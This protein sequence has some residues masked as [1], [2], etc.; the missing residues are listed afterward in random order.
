M[1]VEYV[2]NVD[3]FFHAKN[4]K[5]ADEIIADILS[6][7]RESPKIDEAHAN[8]TPKGGDR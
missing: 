3:I 2:V 5:E 4:K 1:S 8:L 6:D 7:L